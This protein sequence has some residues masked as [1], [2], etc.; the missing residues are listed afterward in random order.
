MPHFQYGNYD[1]KPV[2][3]TDTCIIN[4]KNKT[5]E[6]R[7]NLRDR[8]PEVIFFL[9]AGASIPAGISGVV[10]LVD[11]FK[12]WLEREG[13][14][15]HLDLTE[16]ILEVIQTSSKIN[17]N[18]SKVDIEKLLDIAERLENSDKDIFLDFYENC[19]PR[20]RKSSG[21][22]LISN[23]NNLLTE[24]I[25]RFIKTT[26][27][28]KKLNVRYLKPLN[29]FINSYR[30][31]HI[32]S[33]NYDI[34]IETFCEEND[35][36]Y[37]DGFTP[38]WDP[39][40]FQM[41]DVHLF[42]YKLHGSV[43]WYRTEQGDYEA[44]RLIFTST[45]VN[46]DTRQEGIPLILYPGRKFQYIEPMFDMLL[47]LKKQLDNAKYIFVIGYSFK[48]DHLAKMFR[49]AAKRNPN[50]ILFMISPDA[51]SIYHELL[52]RHIDIDFPHGFYHENFTE[53]FDIDVPSRLKGRVICLPYRIEK[54]IGS[55][56]YHYLRNLIDAESC[57]KTM[58]FQEISDGQFQG[59]VRWDECLVQYA[60]CEHVERI[61]KIIDEKMDLNTLMKI[62]YDVGGKIIIKSFL[63]NLLWDP[64]REKWL[65][66]FREH[67]P[68]TPEK[69]EIK[70]TASADLYLQTKQP[71]ERSFYGG[72]AFSFYK[73][74]FEIYDKHLIFSNE[75][76]LKTAD[77]NG[78]KIN[79]I[80]KY[81]E[82]WR[83]NIPLRNWPNKRRDKYKAKVKVL[84]REINE[85]EKTRSV[86]LLQKIVDQINELEELQA[87]M[88]S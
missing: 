78:L 88:A 9:G 34:C 37:F 1:T 67:L 6:A 71:L 75:S 36:K 61:E 2:I 12:R 87:C 39:D 5:N 13:K 43:R 58:E 48:D 33:T 28:E 59:L 83:E 22:H 54:V 49:Y 66:K 11:D 81:L 65:N 86:G 62:N 45:R 84:Q 35:K 55:L 25:K 17:N 42:L 60:E 32:F 73:T 26:F 68:I 3:E 82:F 19:I 70:T 7:N 53:G 30:T 69:I 44:S 56:Q 46:L 77:N 21:Y 16:R 29:H 79:H 4:V 27:T 31:L 63:N 15:D 8:F 76:A 47:E 18:S 80:L 51:H 72:D 57:E 64:G 50:L 20:L 23:G 74:L 38:S 41:R 14:R 40:E 24:E 52:K 85:Y 10:E